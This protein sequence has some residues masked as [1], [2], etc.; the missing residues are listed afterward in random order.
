MDEIREALARLKMAIADSLGPPEAPGA[1][2]A[3]KS[4]EG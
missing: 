4:A 2:V 1:S 3:F